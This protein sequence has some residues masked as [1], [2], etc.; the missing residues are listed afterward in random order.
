ME[1][2]K[3]K[4][5]SNSGDI[6][7]NHIS[8]NSSED[9]IFLILKL[10]SFEKINSRENFA[11]FDDIYETNDKKKKYKVKIKLISRVKTINKKLSSGNISLR[12]KEKTV[13]RNPVMNEVLFEG[14]FNDIKIEI[15]IPQKALWNFVDIKEGPKRSG[16]IKKYHHANC[17]V[18]QVVSGGK[19]N[20]R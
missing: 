2:N 9:T 16:Y 17:G 3:I 7:V 4:L 12:T 1:N 10:K 11:I 13:K 5:T 8:K 18:T 20:P 19:V 6:I 15:R 14:K